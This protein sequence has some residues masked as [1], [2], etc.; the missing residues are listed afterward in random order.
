MATVGIRELKARLSQYLKRV[1]QGERVVVTDRGRP[2]ALIS[3]AAARAE[4]ERIGEM[5]R[6][7][8]AL[9]DGKRPRGGARPPRLPGATVADAVIE[10]R[11]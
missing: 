3:P 9:W 1:R 4:D 8:T 11:R 2:I 6:D 7:G 5:I 10:D